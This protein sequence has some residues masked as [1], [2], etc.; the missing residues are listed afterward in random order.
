M[1]TDYVAAS[2]KLDAANAAID[3]VIAARQAK[4][5]RIGGLLEMNL[6]FVRSGL[7]TMHDGISDDDGQMYATGLSY[8]VSACDHISEL[9]VDSSAM[10]K[11]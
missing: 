7:D 3:A 1:R 9:R 4:G 6:G 10:A 5:D 2:D 11:R 8:L